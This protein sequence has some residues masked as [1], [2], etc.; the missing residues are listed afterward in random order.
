MINFML[1]FL[2]TLETLAILQYTGPS[3]KNLIF[4]CNNLFSQNMY[5]PAQFLVCC[6]LLEY[7]D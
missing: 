5:R 4:I 1:C 7:D 3:F 2:F 6:L